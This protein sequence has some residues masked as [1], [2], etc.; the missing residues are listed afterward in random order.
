MK[1][2]CEKAKQLFVITHN[3]SYFK[4]IRDWFNP[5]KDRTSIYTI[6]TTNITGIR[7]SNILA[8]KSSLIKYQSEYQYIFSRLY[9]YKDCITIEVD[10]AYLIGNLSR[11]LLEAFLS[12]KYPKKRND[13]KALMDVGIEDKEMLEKV[14][15]FI[16]KYSHNQNIEFYDSLDDN[17][18]SESINIVSDILENI[19]KKIDKKHYEEMVE[20]VTI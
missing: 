8:A 9:E 17:I 13:F 1:N 11:K 6:E 4:L 12:F 18:L 19:I 20:I 3:F 7:Q 14:Y 15:R 10:K 2:E 5:T 16:N